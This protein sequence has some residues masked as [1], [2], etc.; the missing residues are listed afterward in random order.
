MTGSISSTAEFVSRDLGH[1]NLSGAWRQKHFQTIRLLQSTVVS[2]SRPH[3]SF[4]LDIGMATED[5]ESV[6]PQ[7][8]VHFRDGAVKQGRP[9]SERSRAAI[10]AATLAEIEKVGVNT[11]TI[12]AVARRAK[13]G[14][15]TVYRWWPTRTALII[16][17]MNQ[18]PYIEV[19]DTGNLVSDLTEL[20]IFLRDKIF[21]SILGKILTHLSAERGVLEP[22]I[23]VY[24]SGRSIWPVDIANRAISRGELVPWVDPH[25]LLSIA[26]G[27][28]LAHVLLGGPR[29]SDAAIA[30]AASAAAASYAPPESPQ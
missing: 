29:P 14:K 6:A 20:S 17:A 21:S 11:L 24:V 23:D 30:H 12:E 13:V 1:S 15:A 27:P 2:L 16:E 7:Q 8:E 25:V 19:P 26:A 3:V 22:E 28:L 5:F 4:S 9:R 10:L 18:I